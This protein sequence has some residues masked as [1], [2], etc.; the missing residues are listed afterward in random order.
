MRCPLKISIP[1][2]ASS[3]DQIPY[4]EVTDLQVFLVNHVTRMKCPLKL[5]IADIWRKAKSI[6]R[7]SVVLWLMY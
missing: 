4:S 7:S 3:V 6:G 2:G 1:C 5:R